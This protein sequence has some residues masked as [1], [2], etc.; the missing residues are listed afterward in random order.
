MQNF[1]NHL[2][3]RPLGKTEVDW[4]SRVW[5]WGGGAKSSWFRTMFNDGPWY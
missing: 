3:K 2:A 1:G 4:T 5:G